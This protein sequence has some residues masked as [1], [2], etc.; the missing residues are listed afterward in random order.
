MLCGFCY[1]PFVC[2]VGDVDGEP[3]RREARKLLKG[4]REPAW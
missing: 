2:L 4:V 1:M 3:T